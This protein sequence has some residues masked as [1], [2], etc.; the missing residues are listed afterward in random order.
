MSAKQVVP[1]VNDPAVAAIIVNSYHYQAVLSIEL[2]SSIEQQ[3]QT[4]R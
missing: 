4:D 2:F 1:R 3:E